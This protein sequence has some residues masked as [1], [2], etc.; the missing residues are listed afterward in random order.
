MT[1]CLKGN[2]LLDSLILYI[3]YLLNNLT[4][5]SENYSAKKFSTSLG[6]ETYGSE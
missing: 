3:K 2:T 5:V 1:G 4:V 6:F